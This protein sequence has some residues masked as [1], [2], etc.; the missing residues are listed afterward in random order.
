MIEWQHLTIIS[1]LDIACIY[2]CKYVLKNPFLG[3]FIKVLIFNL[4]LID[5]K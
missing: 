3:V 5:E 4:I 2:I 1:L